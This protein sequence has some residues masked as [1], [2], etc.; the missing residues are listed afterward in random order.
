VEIHDIGGIR[1]TGCSFRINT[2]AGCAA[3]QHVELVGSQEAQPL[4]SSHE[5]R[6]GRGAGG[7]VEVDPSH[8]SVR[9]VARCLDPGRAT[10][11]RWA[12]CDDALDVARGRGGLRG[13]PLPEAAPEPEGDGFVRE[14]ACERLQY[15]EEGEDL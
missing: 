2:D 3:T 8:P 1:D 13:P 4:Q 12:E 10:G 6:A 7:L 15:G 9:G 5:V 11:L 14:A